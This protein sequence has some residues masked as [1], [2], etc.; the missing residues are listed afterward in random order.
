MG[1]DAIIIAVFVAIAIPGAVA[2]AIA[3]AVAFEF[4]G[5]EAFFVAFAGAFALILLSAYIGWQALVR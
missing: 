5:I 4:G 1:A 2:A 3:I